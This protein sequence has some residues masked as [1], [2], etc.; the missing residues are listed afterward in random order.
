MDEKEKDN[1]VDGAKQKQ[2]E[3]SDLKNKVGDLQKEIDKLNKK[4]DDIH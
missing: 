3:I 1:L 2:G 4:M